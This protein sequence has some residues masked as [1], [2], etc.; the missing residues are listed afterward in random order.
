MLVYSGVI[1]LCFSRFIFILQ[2]CMV[3][4]GGGYGEKEALGKR[5]LK[6]GVDSCFIS[7]C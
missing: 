3:G 4:G 7:F 6:I 5:P 2:F 1:E